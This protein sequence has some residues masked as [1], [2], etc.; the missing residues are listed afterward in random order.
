MLNKNIAKNL[1]FVTVICGFCLILTNCGF[2]FSKAGNS[3]HKTEYDFSANY[4]KP[5]VIGTIKSDEITES[6][7]IVASRCNP[8]IFWTHN[9]SGDRAFIF[10]INPKGEKLATFIVKDAKN[11]DWED[12]ATTKTNGEC[13]LYLG[14]IG[15]NSLEK[16]EL[17]I[18]RVREPKVSQT[19]DSSKENP[20][21]TETA[22]PIKVSYPDKPHN[23]ETLLVHPT[24]GDIYILTKTKTAPSTIYKLSAKNIKD[25]VN[26]LEKIADYSVPAIPNGFLTGGEISP[27]GQHVILCDYVAGYE[28]DLPTDA[29]NFDEVWKQRPA[30]I[31]LGERFQGEAVCYGL[32]GKTI[33]ATSEKKN[34]PL[35]EVKKR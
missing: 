16:S 3:S 11:L 9:D 8:N 18:Y 28:I 1:A 27:D 25:G 24:T 12:I 14:D 10:A 5:K 22:E 35:I 32:D 15:N 7:G 4:E 21:E 30:K 31:E 6:S 29:K 2:F 19:T 34:S 26:K 13:F 17:T 20:L 33:Y 23:A